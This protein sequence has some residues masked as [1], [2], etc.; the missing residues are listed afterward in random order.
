MSKKLII[1]R[2]AV[3][4][5]DVVFAKFAEAHIV[6]DRRAK[7]DR[8]L[9]YEAYEA[10]CKREGVEPLRGQALRHRFTRLGIGQGGHGFR[11]RYVKYLPS[12]E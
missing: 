2:P 7:T 10:Y 12:N 5:A 11:L 8:S 9:F 1:E 6:K 3:P 4:E